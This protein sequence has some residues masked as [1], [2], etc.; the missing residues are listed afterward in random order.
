MSSAEKTR[1]KLTRRKVKP[2][3]Q[4]RVEASRVSFRICVALG[5]GVIGDCRATFFKKVEAEH[6]ARVSHL[7]WNFRCCRHH[8]KFLYQRCCHYRHAL[9][10]ARLQKRVNGG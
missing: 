9:E 3:I 5:S 7:D 6:A 1:L 10:D 8:K 4:Q 2:C